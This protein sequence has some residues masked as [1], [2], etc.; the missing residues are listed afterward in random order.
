MTLRITRE[1]RSG[2]RATLRLEGRLV[3]RWAALLEAE[4]SDLLR[5]RGA[6]SLDL[7]D[8]GFVD[9]AG[10]DVLKRLSRAGVEIQCRSGPVASVLEGEGVRVTR[11]PDGA[12]DGR[13]EQAD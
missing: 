3:T 9:R 12:N 7:G 5:R 10:V 11:E 6:V 4:C 2:S 8:V 13:P 1:E